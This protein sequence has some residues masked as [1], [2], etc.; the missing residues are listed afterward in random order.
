VEIAGQS[1]EVL[2]VVP[3]SYEPDVLHRLVVAWH[4]LGTS[5]AIARSYYGIEQ[6]AGG[7]AIVLYPAGLPQA[8]FG[9]QTGW[10]LSPTGVDVQLFDA[11]HQGV[12][13]TYCVDV[14]RVF[15]VGHSFGGYMSNTIG[16]AR[17]DRVRAIAPVA[18]GGPYGVCGAGPVAAWLTHGETDETVP[19]AEGEASRDHWLQTNGCAQ[20]HTP[21]DPAA[22]VTYDGCPDGYPVVWC[23]HQEPALGG[24]GWPSFASAAIWTFFAQF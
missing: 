24:H 11:I 12:L 18:G 21:T 4:A 23:P 5:P 2:I 19:F 20:T 14:G 10:D 3:D 22:C 16:C 6:Q 1:R 9:N 8:Q 13:D 7:T 15:S 17:P